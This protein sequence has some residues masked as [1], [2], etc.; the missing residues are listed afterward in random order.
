MNR[1]DLVFP[2]V[3]RRLP[4]DHNYPLYSALSHALKC[5]HDGS[6]AYALSPISGQYI[7]QGELSLDPSRS[8]FRLRIAPEHIPHV[9]PLAGKNFFV[10]GQR[11]RLGVPRIYPLQPATSLIARTV[12]FK[13]AVNAEQFLAA[14]RRELDVM[15]IQGELVIPVESDKA[16]GNTPHRHVL[17]IRGSRIVCY[18]LL[19]RTLQPDQSLRLQEEGI[20]GRRHMGGGFFSPASEEN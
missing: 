15:K 9:L 4:T 17:R 13:N 8:V 19:I 1:I 14:A 2:V 5:L 11:L 18:S 10:M 16:R 12:T 7:G 6:V 20:G 3:G